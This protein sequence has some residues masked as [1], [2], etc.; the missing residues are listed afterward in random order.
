MGAALLTPNYLRHNQSII[1]PG[2]SSFAIWTL[3]IFAALLFLLYVTRPKEKSAKVP[4]GYHE[5]CNENGQITKKGIFNGGIQVSGTKHVYKKDGNLSYTEN[6]VDGVY[7]K[8]I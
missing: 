6:C 8:D 2:F 5:L 4:D 3:V 7:T 1:W